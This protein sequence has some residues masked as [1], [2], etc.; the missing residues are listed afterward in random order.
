MPVAVGVGLVVVGDRRRVVADVADAVAV[1]VALVLVRRHEAVVDAV[2]NRVVVGI[3]VA[4]VAGVVLVVVPLVG[5]V[6]PLAVVL[7]I[8]DEVVVLVAVRRRVAEVAQ[9]VA[10]DVRLA[11]VLDEHAVVACIEHGVVVVI[12][13]AGVA[14]SIGVGVQLRGV[15]DLD[16]VVGAVEAAI[17]VVVAV[18]EVARS[19]AVGVAVSEQC[20][21]ERVPDVAGV[22]GREPIRSAGRPQ[23]RLEDGEIALR[24]EVG[25]RGEQPGQHLVVETLDLRAPDSGDLEAAEEAAVRAQEGDLVRDAV[26]GV[27]PAAVSRREHEGPH[28]VRMHRLRRVA[29][30]ARPDG[31]PFSDQPV[32]CR[33]SLRRRPS[34][35]RSAHPADSCRRDGP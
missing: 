16:A 11:R 14:Q 2:H 9:P 8:V 21:R 12:R 6:Q 23:G 27:H 5:V 29:H 20:R 15:R 7:E 30:V 32:R 3:H 18:C 31:R 10:V 24:D 17:V 13:V 22:G 28:V 25:V 35:A 19:V 33:S 4:R 26:V 1:A 34:S